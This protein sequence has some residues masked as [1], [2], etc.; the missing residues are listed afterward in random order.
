MRQFSRSERL[1][2][3]ILRDVSTLVPHEFG[4]SVATFINFT[5]TRMSAD[6]K[7]AT[8]Y[9]SVLGDE[10]KRAEAQNFLDKQN[11][12]IRHLLAGQLRLRLLPELI[13]KF[14]PS[15]EESI[16]LEKLFNEI[17]S[18]SRE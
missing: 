15:V 7:Y 9:W 3:Q 14:D 4:T 10:T 5:R 18:T 16:R 12:R 1:G 2:E 6:L 11:K 8:I 17:R 13:F